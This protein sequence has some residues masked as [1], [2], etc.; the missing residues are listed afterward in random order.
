MDLN[1]IITRPGATIVDVR[2]PQEF[3]AGHVVGSIHIPL[4]EIPKRMD[5]LRALATPLVLCCARGIRSGQAVAYL[6]QRG[7]TD[8][9]NGGGWL[10]VQILRSASG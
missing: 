5:E 6:Q 1:E 4:Q 9:H 2:T 3:Q 8:V 10:D 7:F